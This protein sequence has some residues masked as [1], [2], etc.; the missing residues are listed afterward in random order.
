[1][2]EHEL[3]VGDSRALGIEH[4]PPSISKDSGYADIRTDNQ[5]SQE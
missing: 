4:K 3:I 1:M 5:V 2:R